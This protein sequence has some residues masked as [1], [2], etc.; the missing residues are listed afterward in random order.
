MSVTDS[1]YLLALGIGL[2]VM[3]AVYIGLRRA[4]GAEDQPIRRTMAIFSGV[5]GIVVTLFLIR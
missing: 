3:C 2:L 5:A 1:D 4:F